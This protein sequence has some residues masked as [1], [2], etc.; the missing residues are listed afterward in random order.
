MFQDANKMKTE[1]K[2]NDRRFKYISGKTLTI[3]LFVFLHLLYGIHNFIHTFLL[4]DK[5]FT[6][7]MVA[8]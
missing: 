2:K 1:M 3:E 8:L 4:L 7:I 5:I 6:L